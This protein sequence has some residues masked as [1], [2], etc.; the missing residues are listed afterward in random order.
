MNPTPEPLPE[1]SEEELDRMKCAQR[2]EQKQHWEQ[3]PD[4]EREKLRKK[5]FSAS[6]TKMGRLTGAKFQ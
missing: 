5:L 2:R 4:E 1:I 3:M 6:G